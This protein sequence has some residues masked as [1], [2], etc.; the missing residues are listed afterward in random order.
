MLQRW[1]RGRRGLPAGR[2]RLRGF[3]SG[4]LAVAM[5]TG[6]G[7]LPAGAD[8]FGPGFSS[9]W[10]F[11]SANDRAVRAGVVDLIERKQAGQFQAPIFNTTNTTNIAGDQINC[12]VVATTIGNSGSA[13]NE[14]QSGAPTVL[15]APEVHAAST[16]NVAGGEAGGPLNANG[17]SGTNTVNTTQ[18]VDGSTQTSNV[19]D[20]QQG[21][22]TGDV[23][24]SSSSL[25]QSARND[26]AINSSPLN[27]SVA[28]SSACTWW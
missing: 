16:G 28:D 3:A 9:S 11:R 20:T 17:T 13:L 22:V 25:D 4:M 8:G 1:K 15:N 12:D 6:G 18:G 10:Q 27:S 23:G 21:G 24:G 19:G 2:N 26:Q 5:A 7:A 14:G